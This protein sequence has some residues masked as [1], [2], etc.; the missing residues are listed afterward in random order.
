MKK[1]QESRIKKQ[2]QF[3]DYKRKT[4]TIKVGDKRWMIGDPIGALERVGYF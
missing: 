2:E 3:A 1:D 4:M